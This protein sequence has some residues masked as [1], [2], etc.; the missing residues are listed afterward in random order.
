MSSETQPPIKSITE[1]PKESPGESSIESTT[2]ISS[3]EIKN[4]FNEIKQLSEEH[5]TPIVVTLF[6]VI[7]RNYD[8]YR[9][10]Y[11]HEAFREDAGKAG[12]IYMDLLEAFLSSKKG[13]QNPSFEAP[14]NHPNKEGHLIAA[15]EIRDRLI[16]EG[17]I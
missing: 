11:I 6:P 17:L 8:D 16:E 3:P 13:V 2:P 15:E 4:Y 5:Q 12:L 14:Y 7:I 1:S 10:T 9:L